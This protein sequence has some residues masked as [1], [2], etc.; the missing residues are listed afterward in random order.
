MLGDKPIPAGM[1]PAR[2]GLGDPPKAPMQL[3]A[4]PSTRGPLFGGG[5][6]W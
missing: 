5:C 4:R 3:G 2:M 6:C 1:D